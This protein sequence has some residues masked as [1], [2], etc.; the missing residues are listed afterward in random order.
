MTSTL[1]PPPPPNAEDQMWPPERELWRIRPSAAVL[2][3]VVIGG[4]AFDVGIRHP[5]GLLSFLAIAL[6]AVAG[7]YGG[8]VRGP[9][10]RRFVVLA[11]LPASM[12][13]LRDSAWLTPLN[14]AA[15]IILLVLAVAVRPEPNA[16]GRA[17]GRMLHPVGATE[18]AV[19]SVELIARS[20]GAAVIGHDRLGRRL[21]RLA[22]GLALGAPVVAVLA[23]LLAASDA[24][25]RSW[26]DSPFGIVTAVEHSFFV[27]FGGA[28]TAALAGH[29]AWAEVRPAG[30]PRR[31]LGPTEA[32]I[33]LAGVVVTYAGFVV[34]QVI[35]I[36]AGAGYVERT[37]GLTYA[38][39]A[40]AGFFQLVAAAV[41][42]LLV[43]VGIRRYRQPSSPRVARRLR[44]LE[45]STVGLTLAVVLVAIRRLFLYEA[46]FGLTMLRL[47][48]ILFAAF[49]G[50]VFVLTGLSIAGRLGREPIE[51]ALAGALVLLLGSNI[52][53][54]EAIVAERNIERFGGTS[55]L[56]VSYLVLN[57]GTDALPAMLS[58]P[59]VS[60]VL[61]AAPPEIDDRAIVFNWSRDR[62]ADALADAC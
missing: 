3:S 57:L 21:L 56:D 45:L 43:L 39:Y 34:A 59:A 9:L 20:A 49:I 31:P 61:C 16:L 11:L 13:M 30:Q 12:L 14:I 27:A 6:T 5:M 15:V 4:V 32:S 26:F 47:S 23:T 1:Q 19:R 40:R 52:A 35:A 7:I 58:D 2:A 51:L 48:T 24:L 42:T 38:E 62:A 53:N 10:A 50:F 60:S 28:L 54:P 46:E 37:T 22:R 8:W 41:L 17:L 44:A 29:G 25:F 36:T 55:E 18:P 33:V